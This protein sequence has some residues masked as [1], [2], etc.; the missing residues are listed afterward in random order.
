LAAR[1]FGSN[2]IDLRNIPG[3]LH[4]KTGLAWLGGRQ[5]LALSAVADHEAL[6]GWEVVMVPEGE[7]YAANCIRVNGAVLVASGFPE[8]AALVRSLGHDVTTLDMSE[9][10]KMDGGLSCLSVR[11]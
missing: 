1:G 11:W 4:L 7:E 10:R 5:L 2:L 3:L 8:T 9:Y 6:R